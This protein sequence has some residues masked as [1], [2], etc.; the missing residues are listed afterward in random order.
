MF[1]IC[2]GVVEVKLLVRHEELIRRVLRVES[3]VYCVK[4]GVANRSF[5]QSVA[6]ICVLVF[7][8]SVGVAV[9]IRDNIFIQIMDCGVTAQTVIRVAKT[10]IYDR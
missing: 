8:I 5:R 4:T 2:F 1:F 10:V 7:V 9:D 3:R 6:F